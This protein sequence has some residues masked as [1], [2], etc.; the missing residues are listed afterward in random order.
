MFEVSATQRLNYSCSTRADYVNIIIG[1]CVKL[2]AQMAYRYA[3]WRILSCSEWPVVGYTTILELQVV[4]AAFAW[5]TMMF[6]K[7]GTS[8]IPLIPS[9]D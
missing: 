3:S 7:N 1:S 8:T 9:Q 4:L 5:E 6:R 2:L